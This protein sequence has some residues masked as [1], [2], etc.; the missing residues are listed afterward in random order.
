[1]KEGWRSQSALVQLLQRSST[2]FQDLFPTVEAYFSFPLSLR[3]H[4]SL[5]AATLSHPIPCH[6]LAGTA[7]HLSLSSAHHLWLHNR[8]GRR[9]EA[10]K[11]KC[12]HRRSRENLGGTKCTIHQYQTDINVP[13]QEP[14]DKNNCTG[15]TFSFPFFFIPAT[16]LEQYPTKKRSLH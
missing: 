15:R 12:C 4:K 8:E 6:P 13:V 1:M 9:E 14:L 10:E 3:S 7:V 5:Q 2:A 11:G 16:V